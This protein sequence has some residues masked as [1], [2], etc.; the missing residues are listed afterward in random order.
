MAD[1]SLD[2]GEI[3]SLVEMLIFATRKT[4]Y[5]SVNICHDHRSGEYIESST[6]LKYFS[7]PSF[8]AKEL[9]LSRWCEEMRKLLGLK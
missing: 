9:S 8:R 7:S 2:P 3:R 1:V 5:N 4:G 6:D